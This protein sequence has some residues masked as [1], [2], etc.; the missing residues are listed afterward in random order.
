M[1]THKSQACLTLLVSALL[2]AGCGQRDATPTTD[3][4]PTSQGTIPPPPGD[5][6]PKPADSNTRSAVEANENAGSQSTVGTA[7]SGAPPYTLNSAPEGNTAPS[8][9]SKPGE[10]EKK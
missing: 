9:G 2:L 4:P 7:A 5:S 10:P 3:V 8:Q 1:L 6:T